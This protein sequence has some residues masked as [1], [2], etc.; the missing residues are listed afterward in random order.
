MEAERC[1]FSWN[2]VNPS[3][4]GPAADILSC[5]QHWA[6]LVSPSHPLCPLP[7]VISS[8]LEE[9][10]QVLCFRTL[11]LKQVCGWILPLCEDVTLDLW[12]RQLSGRE[13]RSSHQLKVLQSH[14]PKVEA[15]NS[16]LSQLLFRERQ[17]FPLLMVL[18]YTTWGWLISSK[19]WIH[20]YLFSFRFFVHFASVNCKLCKKKSRLKISSTMFHLSCFK[21]GVKALCTLHGHPVVKPSSFRLNRNLGIDRK[22]KGG[23][24]L[25]SSSWIAHQP[26]IR[27]YLSDS[28]EEPYARLWSWLLLWW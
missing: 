28:G 22:A 16:V 18:Y 1:H 4:L 9:V 19:Q 23:L 14:N 3:L 7:L 25:V 15:L 13:G 5:V 27:A 2:S 12:F 11:I 24:S 20:S 26:W 10:S 17:L 6:T 8:G 21:C